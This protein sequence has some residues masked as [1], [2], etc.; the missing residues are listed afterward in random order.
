MSYSIKTIIILAFLVLSIDVQ[1]QTPVNMSAQAGYTY[2]ENFSDI[3]NWTFNTSPS[4]GTFIAGT[5]ASAW[6]GNGVNSTGSIPDGK[7]ITTKSDSVF[8]TGTSGGVQKGSG[9]LVL[10]TTG[11]SDNSSSVAMDFYLNYTTLSAGTLSFDWS[12]VNNSTGDRKSSLK[13]YT[14][15]DGSNFT[16]LTGAAVSNITNNNVTSGNISNINLP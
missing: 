5:G 12:S 9:N 16:E 15:I 13:V 11:S 8:V 14:S 3:A 10:L 2:T 7:K 4:N 6:R 1:A